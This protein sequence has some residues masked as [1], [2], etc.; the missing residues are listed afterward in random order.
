MNS[1]N[2]YWFIAKQL[3]LNLKTLPKQLL[4]SLPLDIKAGSAKAKGREPENC[5]C[6]VFDYKLGCFDDVHV[7]I[8]VDAPHIYS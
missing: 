7:Y 3:N 8:N 5:L 4:G 6:R 1:K 2:L